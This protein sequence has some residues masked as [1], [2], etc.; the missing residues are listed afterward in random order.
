MLK[1]DDSRLQVHD[2]IPEV[3]TLSVTESVTTALPVIETKSDSKPKVKAK[4][5]VK[6]L[7]KAK[8][9]TDEADKDRQD[10]KILELKIAELESKFV[11]LE[12]ELNIFLNKKK[13]KKERKEKKVKCKC[14]DEKV[15]TSDCKCETK[16]S[17]K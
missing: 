16:K 6:V 2:I 10:V 5:K 3:A 7:P 9:P 17:D 15:D 1:K 8:V 13:K 14:K 11:K 12:T 4:P